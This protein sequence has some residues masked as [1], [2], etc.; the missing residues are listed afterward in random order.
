MIYCVV[1]RDSGRRLAATLER[2]YSDDPGLE[3]IVERRTEN[4]RRRVERRGAG[5][6]ARRMPSLRPDRRRIRNF[7]GRR[8]AERRGVLIPTTYD[9]PPS[10]GLR[11]HADQI[12]F[13]GRI[14]PIGD[15]VED[16]AGARLATRIQAGDNAAFQEIYAAWFDRI[17]NFFRIVTRRPDDVEPAMQ[18][19]FLRLHA[20]MAD[21]DYLTSFRTW[22]ATT[23][24]PAY[25]VDADWDWED[26]DT[27]V[28]ERWAGNADPSV[29]EWLADSE[30]SV[31]VGRLPSPQR[32]VV[33]LHYVL[34]LSPMQVAEVLDR[35]VD[36]IN[37][38]HARAL[39][40]ISGC[41]TSLSRRPGYSGRHPMLARRRPA[42]VIRSRQR[43]LAA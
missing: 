24:T 1:P 32:E 11:R 22:L 19:A 12:Q 15:W 41:V 42:T 18:D 4:R 14:E 33:A 6:F 35:P 8:I 34:G 23:I 3:V 20:S 16:T 25:E 7:D 10:R 13:F 29:L 30:L 2:I 21:Y 40:F 27:R 37:D 38:H 26:G 31:L 39:R 5:V 9:L 28:L 43:A 36:E 17:Y